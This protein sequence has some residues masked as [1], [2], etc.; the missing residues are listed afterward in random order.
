MLLT[1]LSVGWRVFG[2]IVLTVVGA[3]LVGVAMELTDALLRAGRRGLRRRRVAAE[4]VSATRPRV[5]APDHPA[6]SAPDVRGVRLPDAGLVAPRPLQRDPVIG[7]DVFV[8]ERQ[9][10]LYARRN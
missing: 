6:V 2:A 1:G 9:R 3:M 5:A 4:L 10:R 7:R 8:Q